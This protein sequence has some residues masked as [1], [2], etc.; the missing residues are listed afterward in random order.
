[1]DSLD[2]G[3]VFFEALG[4]P[5]YA[6][7]NFYIIKQKQSVWSKGVYLTTLNEVYHA[8][9]TRIQINFN[10][11]K[12]KVTGLKIEDI[13]LPMK[14]F[15]GGDN[16]TLVDKETLDKLHLAI[17]AA[18]YWDLEKEKFSAYQIL[19]FVEYALW[20]MRNEFQYV[21]G[22]KQING[23]R[24]RTKSYFN[25]LIAQDAPFFD[26]PRF[27]AAIRELNLTQQNRNAFK[28]TLEPF[29]KAAHEIV[30]LW[31]E[32]IAPIVHN[33]AGVLDQE[34]PEMVMV[35]FKSADLNFSWWNDQDHFEIRPTKLY[36]AQDFAYYAAKIS[37]L[38]MN[39]ILHEAIV[40]DPNDKKN[41]MTDLIH[42]IQL[43]Q[44][45]EIKEDLASGGRLEDPYR[46]WVWQWFRKCGYQAERETLKGTG[47]IDLKIIHPSIGTKV[48]EFKGWWNDKK[49]EV[50][51]QTCR[52]LT[53]F[54]DDAVI[55]IINNTGKDIVPEYKVIV[56]DHILNIIGEFEDVRPD[57]NKGYKYYSTRYN[58]NG[59]E[60]VIYHFIF[61]GRVKPNV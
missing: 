56:T 12:G 61:P 33:D 17:Q 50:I 27:K 14:E 49:K 43:M 51:Q 18:G 45:E 25:Y 40:T 52:Y 36:L 32:K 48:I 37:N 59:S 60:K 9:I 8:C 19:S 24:P 1:M 26:F 57:T 13:K 35:E 28:V 34:P 22:L 38:I 55:F 31:N 29:Q 47:H 53:E 3:S 10:A 23:F 30:T 11:K 39:E 42:G 20:F 46:N 41:F 54:E 2:L 7:P 4:H 5:E 44:E 58:Y 15:I 21:A 16:E 6:R